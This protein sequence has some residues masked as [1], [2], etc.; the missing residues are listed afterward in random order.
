MYVLMDV[1]SNSGTLRISGCYD[2]LELQ[3]QYC[4]F[5]VKG[6]RVGITLICPLRAVPLEVFNKAGA[7]Y[8]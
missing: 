3:R 8:P 7:L 2:F 6:V 1:Q 5:L 4:N